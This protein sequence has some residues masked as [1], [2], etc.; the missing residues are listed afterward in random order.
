MQGFPAGWTQP[1]E[2]LSARKGPRWKLVG[3][4]VSVGVSEW[5]GRRLREPGDPILEGGAKQ[6]GARWPTAAF[7]AKGKV[8][9]VNLSLW[10]TCE[11][12]QHLSDVVDID[13]AQ[14]LS[15]RGAAGFL[16]KAHRGTLRFA[17]GFLDDISEHAAHMNDELSVA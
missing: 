11:P 12:Y 8:W 10:P 14:S 6:E 17:E 1:A 2:G 9:G 3:N 16:S 5:L 15:A 4:A 13:L 7:G